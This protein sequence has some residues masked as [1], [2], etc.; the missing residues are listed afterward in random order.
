[1]HGFS[2][3]QFA[4]FYEDSPLLLHKL[5]PSNELAG[6]RQTARTDEGSFIQPLLAVI[7]SSVLLDIKLQLRAVR[8]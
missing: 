4:E 6:S 8:T 2:T 5:Y 3:V 7:D 1:M